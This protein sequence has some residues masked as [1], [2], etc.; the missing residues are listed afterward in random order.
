MIPEYT[1]IRLLYFQSTVFLINTF[2]VSAYS[3]KT[4][5]WSMHGF[6]VYTTNWFIYKCILLHYLQGAASMLM[7]ASY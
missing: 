1:M 3:I 5:S 2:R 7:H 4:Y 6:S